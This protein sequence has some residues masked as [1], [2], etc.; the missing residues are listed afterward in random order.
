ME[1]EKKRKLT[2]KFEYL[3]PIDR[4]ENSPHIVIWLNI[5]INAQTDQQRIQKKTNG[6]NNSQRFL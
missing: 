4:T 3:E 2:R 5:F 1:R 6:N